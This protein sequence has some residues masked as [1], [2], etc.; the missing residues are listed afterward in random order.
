MLQILY[1]HS[2]LCGESKLP[3][4]MSKNITSVS[5]CSSQRLPKVYK[6]QYIFLIFLKT[7]KPEVEE[8]NLLINQKQ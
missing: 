3:F 2:L 8:I 1:Y 5:Q 4:K 7:S 6:I